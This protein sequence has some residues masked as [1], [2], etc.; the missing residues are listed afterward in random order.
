MHEPGRKP[1]VDVALSHGSTAVSDVA[2]RAKIGARL[3]LSDAVFRNLTR[4]A[5]GEP[6]KSSAF[7]RAAAESFG[8]FDV[9]KT[10]FVSVGKMRGV[11][12]AICYQDPHS[13]KLS[14]H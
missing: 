8:S 12:W 5:A 10:A 14:N 6:N 1:V 3:R 7:A 11:G 9:W 4:G 2:S 13:G